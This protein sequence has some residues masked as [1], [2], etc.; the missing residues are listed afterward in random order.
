MNKNFKF[1]LIT[2]SYKRPYMLRTCILNSANQ[3]YI[4]FHHSIVINQGDGSEYN[5]DLLFDDII[6]PENSKN[7]LVDPFIEQRFPSEKLAPPKYIINYKTNEDQQA[8]YISTITNI[9][10]QHPDIYNTIDYILKWDDDE[11]HKANYL[12]NINEYINKNPGYDIYTSP[13]GSQLNNYHLNTGRSYGHLG[14]CPNDS[15]GMPGTMAFNKSAAEMI[16]LTPDDEGYWEFRGGG[17]EDTAWMH[18]WHNNNLKFKLI[19]LPNEDFIWHIHG[20]RVS[21]EGNVSIS[22]WA[23]D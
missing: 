12:K 2:P 5:Y 11:I 18:H 21:G 10:K 15:I 22:D 9:I 7:I 3:S 8:N 16:L 20:G 6:L 17:F 1:L 4:S 19:D 13:V 14:G 23:A